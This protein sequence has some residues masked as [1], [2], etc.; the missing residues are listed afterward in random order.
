MRKGID[1]MM[2]KCDT[3]DE[4]MQHNPSADRAFLDAFRTE[5]LCAYLD[6]LKGL[7]TCTPGARTAAAD[8][9]V[10]TVR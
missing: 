8:H 4:I 3:I 5:D 1:D 7:D 10:S 2:P 6:R 9:D